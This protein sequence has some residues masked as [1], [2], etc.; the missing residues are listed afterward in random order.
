[1]VLTIAYDLIFIFLFK[2]PLIRFLILGFLVVF[3][4]KNL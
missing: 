3:E 2:V 1:M 4:I